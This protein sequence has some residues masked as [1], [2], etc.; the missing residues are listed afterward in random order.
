MWSMG[1]VSRG[2]TGAITTAAIGALIAS[3]SGVLAVTGA[4][5]A[6]ALYLALKA[7]G[8]GPY[9]G[10]QNNIEIL[11]A[12][13]RSRNYI[14]IGLTSKGHTVSH[15]IVVVDGLANEQTVGNLPEGMKGTL[16]PLIGVNTETFFGPW[17]GAEEDDD[18]DEGRARI[19]RIHITANR[20]SAA[21]TLINRKHRRSELDGTLGNYSYLVNSC[22]T[23]AVDICRAA[24]LQPPTWACTPTLLWLWGK[25]MAEIQTHL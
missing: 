18:F 10:G 12:G 5:T 1:G 16:K 20:A 6:A 21:L 13:K 25:L 9:I 22:T 24:G 7:A 14:G 15:N 17:G 11:V 8:F 4:V 19:R 2:L 23:N 3:V